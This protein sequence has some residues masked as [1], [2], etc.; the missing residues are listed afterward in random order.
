MDKEDLYMTS[1]EKA[2]RDLLETEQARGLDES[3]IFFA[4]KL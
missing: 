3:Q 2:Q 4:L 1:L